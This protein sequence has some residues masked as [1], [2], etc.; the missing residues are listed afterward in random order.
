M[1]YLWQMLGYEEEINPTE[2]QVK[3]RYLLH[4]QIRHSNIKLKSLENTMLESFMELPALEVG[5]V[6]QKND[7]ILDKWVKKIGKN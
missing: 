1:D 7:D 5:K 3:Q 6:V 4:K 2:K